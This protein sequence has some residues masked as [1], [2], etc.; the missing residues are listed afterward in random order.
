MVSE[1]G[2]NWGLLST[3]KINRALIQVLQTSRRNRLR[4]VASRRQ[5]SAEAYAAQ[6]KIERALGSYEAL[7]ADPEIDVIYISLPNDMHAEWSIK[8]LRAGKHVMCEK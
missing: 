2:L 3:A 4:A 7:L 1:R 6:W 5:D 8:A